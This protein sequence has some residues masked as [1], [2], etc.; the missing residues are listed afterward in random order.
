MSAPSVSARLSRRRRLAPTVALVGALGSA[1]YLIPA[2]HAAASV[3]V[4]TSTIHGSDGKTY[5]AT[6]HLVKAYEP[7]ARVSRTAADKATANAATAG[8]G[9]E[10]L[11]VWA[12]DENVADTKGSDVTS[13]PLAVNPVKLLNV[14]AAKAGIAPDFLAVIDA[15]KTSPTYGKVVNT[16]T[17]GPLVEN[18]PHHMQYVWHKGDKVYAGGLFASTSYTFDVTDL[19]VVKLA[20]ET[21]P[22][23]T[24]CGSIPDAFATLPDHTAYATYMGGPVAPGPCTYSDGTTRVGNGYGGT[25]GAL[26]HFDA[27]GKVLGIF[28]TASTTSESYTVPATGATQPCFDLPIVVTSS[29]ANPHGIQVRPDLHTLIASDYAEPRD[30]IL[31]PVKPP[32]AG[33]FRDTVRTFDI[34]NENHPVLRSVSHMPD[35]P[36]KE[37]NP[38]HE[39]P[40]GIMEVSVTNQHKHKGA[41]AESMCGGVIYYTPDITAKHPVWREV[42]DDTTASAKVIPQVTEGGGCD[43]GGWV[44]V[45]PTDHYLYHTVIGRSAGALGP[46]DTGSAKM[47]YAL[48]VSKL[49]AAGTGFHCDISTISQVYDGGTAA[50]CPKLVSVLPITDGTS[51]GPHWGAPDNFTRNADGSFSESK[52]WSRIAISDYFV[53]RTGV[54]GNHK[55]CMVDV[56][57][58]GKLTLDTTFRDEDEGTPCVDFNRTSWP[59]GKDGDAKPHSE[60]FVVAG[61]DVR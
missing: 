14:D 60:L 10:Y 7:Y 46:D 48:D 50:D 4:I 1:A 45:D 30:I 19:P 51:G 53:A 27:N 23:D 6:N 9:H 2:G 49:V 11:L 38:G 25:P 17:V 12:G 22:T 32:D 35:G 36:R 56:G 15:D 55:V 28:P 40:R 57:K 61:A 18:E 8:H 37:Q 5:W 54:D 52:T 42:F 34:S 44:A 58:K 59:H 26:V 39:E 21:L 41:F 24:A 3:D 13:L 20:N 33:I 31:D 16:V 47:I 43:G 29:C